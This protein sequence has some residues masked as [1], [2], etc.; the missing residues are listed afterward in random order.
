MRA[1]N[2]SQNSLV[3]VRSKFKEL[4]F[5]VFQAHNPHAFHQTN[6][7]ID[8]HERIHMSLALIVNR[9][10]LSVSATSHVFGRLTQSRTPMGQTLEGAGKKETMTSSARGCPKIDGV[11]TS[12]F[13]SMRNYLPSKFSFLAEIRA[14]RN[15]QASEEHSPCFCFCVFGNEM[16]CIQAIR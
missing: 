13:T 11:G 3:D 6:G 16:N 12:L 2:L 10:V 9:I 4:Y 15:A 1:M 8:R 14:S 5:C 7:R